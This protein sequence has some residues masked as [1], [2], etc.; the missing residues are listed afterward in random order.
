MRERERE[1]GRNKGE[2][3]GKRR[4]EEQDVRLTIELV[5]AQW[6]KNEV[7]NKC[8]VKSNQI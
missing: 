8:W 1:R 4:R 6:T 2:R 7:F 5:S 3:E